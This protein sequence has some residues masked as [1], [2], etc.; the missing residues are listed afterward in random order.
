MGKRDSKSY[1]IDSYKRKKKREK[2]WED[3]KKRT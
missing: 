1:K 3:G 2:K